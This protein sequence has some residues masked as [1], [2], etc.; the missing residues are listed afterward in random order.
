MGDF[1][2]LDAVVFHFLSPLLPRSY[3]LTLEDAEP[4]APRLQVMLL[5][6]VLRELPAIGLRYVDVFDVRPDEIGTGDSIEGFS[7]GL[8]VR[9]QFADCPQ[10]ILDD[11]M[12]DDNVRVR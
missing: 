7:A 9:V 1:N 3:E 2:V 6:A 12:S 5:D 4:V 8:P 10:V 11:V